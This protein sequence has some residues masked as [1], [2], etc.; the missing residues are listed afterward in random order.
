MSLRLALIGAGRMGAHHARVVSQSPGVVLDED[1][2][3]VRATSLDHGI[4]CLAFAFEEKMRINVSTEGLAA[5][6]LPVG[7]WLNEAKRAVR[8]DSPKLRTRPRHDPGL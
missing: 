6:G 3:R 8:R 2:F 5:L 1:S 4:A 7:P